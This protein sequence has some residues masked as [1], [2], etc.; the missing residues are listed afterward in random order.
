MTKDLRFACLF[1][2]HINV[3]S[4]LETF[5]YLKL[6]TKNDLISCNI[7]SNMNSLLSLF[8]TL[9]SALSYFTLHKYDKVS[10][11]H[12]GKTGN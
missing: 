6:K 5:I 9:Q 11:N 3:Y 1:G 2:Y 8:N 7:N 4:V 12:T 10:L